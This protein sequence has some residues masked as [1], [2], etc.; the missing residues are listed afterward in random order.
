MKA[1][2]TWLYFERGGSRAERSEEELGGKWERKRK[3]EEFSTISM[4][5]N[6]MME[7]IILYGNQSIDK[8]DYKKKIAL[9]AKQILGFAMCFCGR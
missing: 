5:E 6:A 3:D 7:P 4:C 1:G 9:K 8:V 2:I